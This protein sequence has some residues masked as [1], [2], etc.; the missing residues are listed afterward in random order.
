MRIVFGGETFPSARAML[1]ERLPADQFDIWRNPN[2]LPSFGAVDV[3][4][5]MMYTID[6]AAMDAIRPRL[7]HQ[8]GSGLEGVDLAA[9]RERQIAVAAIPATGGNAESVAEHVVLLILA[10]LRQ[11][12]QAQANI[13]AGVLGEPL[14]RMLAGRTVCLW[15]LGAT[16]LSL[17]RRLKAL[18]VTLLGLTRDPKSSKV[19]AY[20]LDACYSID[21]RDA[22][23]A[24]TEI[25]VL[26]VR[27][28]AATRG[29]VDRSVF[30]AL[31]AGAYF[32]NPARGPL[33]DYDALFDAL[34][35]GRLAGAAL[36]VFWHEPVSPD[37]PLLALPNVIATPHIAGVTDLSYS[38]ILDR[39]AANLERFRRGESLLNRSA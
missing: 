39:V 29:L 18:G 31:H 27:L 34:S 32:V 30:A 17:S 33:V 16:A 13:R 20:G 7:I 9:A 23:L 19:A 4:V 11:L 38:E 22:C 6:A 36:D 24:R 15:G 12:P 35:T 21:D 5:P 8:I 14:G 37:E 3:L 28:S 1:Q 2:E 25:L 26:C 10:L